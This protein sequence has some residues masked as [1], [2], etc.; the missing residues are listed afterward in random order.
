MDVPLAVC[1]PNALVL[2]E[3]IG[4]PGDRSSMMDIL[5]KPKIFQWHSI[6]T[7]LTLLILVIF[8][9]S[10]WSLSFFISRMLRD[11]MQRLLGDQQFSAVSFLADEVNQQ[12]SDRV[13][14]LEKV[15]ARISPALLA[16]TAALQ[17]FLEEH[18]ILQDPF[19]SG[20]VVLNI[21]GTTIAE[22][23][24][25]AERIGV[26]YMDRDFAVGALRDGKA[27]IGR[28]VV[29]KK[30][31]APLFVIAVPIRD[32]QGQV[33]GALAGVTNLGLP[34]FLDRI[35]EHQ[36]GKTGGYLLVAPQYRL[37]VTATDKSRI[38]E[39]YPDPGVNPVLDRFI[40]GYEGSAVYTSVT[41]VEILSS[42]RHMPVA[43]WDMV[44]NLPTAEAFA[45]I[46]DMQQRMLFAT[47]LLTLLAAALTWWILRHQLSP[48]FDTMQTLASMADDSQALQPLPITS[49]DEIGQLIGGF[50]R[51]LKTLEQREEALKASE[52]F[53][54]S[55]LNSVA[56]EIAVVDRDGIIQAVNER[57][58]RFA[59]E[60]GSE[61]GRPA[62]H[63]DV[64][65]DY[66]A[67]SKAGSESTESMS[68]TSLTSVTAREA[69]R[70]IESVLDGRLPSFSLEYP[71]HSPQKQRWF[72]MI[73]MPL[74][75]NGSQ[76]AVISHTDIT[77]LK[78]AEQYEQFRSRILE[79]LAVGEPLPVILEALALGVE[80]VNPR[81]LCSIMLL[82][83][84]GRHLGIGASPSLPDFYNVAM[85]G[86]EIGEAG[87]GSGT[88]A[89]TGQ[90]VIV[91]NIAM[92]P[93][94]EPYKALAASAGLGACWA[95]PILSATGQ[96]LGTF[97]IYYPEART[98]T[99]SD[100]YTI[101]QSA[102]LASI[103][104][105]RNLAAEKLR[106]SE[107]LYRL[108]TED[109]TDVAWKLDRDLVFTYIS[110]TDERLRGYKAEE[111]IGHHVFET[112]T[113]EGIAYL[114]ERI[115]QRRESER[116]GIQ[117]GTI[118]LEVQQRC[119][120]GR[121][122]WTEIL[123]TPE[124]DE[125]G[126]ITG[127]H[128]VSRDIGERK[129]AEEAL[130]EQKDFF[131]LIAE[132]IG[133]FIA[134]LDLEGRRLYNSPS[135][136]KFFGSPDDLFGSD[137]FAEIHPDDRERVKQVFRETVHTGVGRQI[138][139][140]F[141]M[142]DGSIR[143]MES[144]GNAIR[145]GE[146][147]VDRVVV[148]SHDVTERKQLEERLRLQSDLNQRYLDTTLALMVELDG[149]GKITMINHALERLLGYTE[150]ELLGRDWFAACIPEPESTDVVLPVFRQIM[151]GEIKPFIEFENN[152]LCRDGRQRMIAWYNSYLT[153]SAGQIVGSFS[154]G[155]DI[156]ERIQLAEQVRQL[157]FHDQLTQLPNRRLL[158]DRLSQAMAASKRS[159]CFGAVMF[160][161]LDNFKPLNDAHGHEVGDL[162]LIEVADRLRKCVRERDTVARFGGDEFVVMV[163]ELVVDKSGS[164]DQASV[165]AEKIR[166]ALAR[167]YLLKI[168]HDGAAELSV[169]HHCTASIG[170]TLFIDH[171]ASQNEIFKWADSAMYQAKEAGGNLIRFH[172]AKGS[173]AAKTAVE[174][175]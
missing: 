94:W 47:L 82:D 106:N 69:L 157:A 61:P 29:G 3:G 168:R 70:G 43:G 107:A 75:H 160:L 14:A 24:L 96:V 46:R 164:I 137:S 147:R 56:A 98:P 105:E 113:D 162:L 148:V 71:C 117:T 100:L 58:L 119:K 132:N 30:L 11:D 16:D 145:D 87:G 5:V 150:G 123:S 78:R 74:G 130:R 153:D 121:L 68:A 85:D 84:E 50:N 15:A 126:R 33:I 26:N 40:D 36:Y 8:V 171:Q 122:I 28:P 139:Y 57:W 67:F 159:A 125:N 97:A 173:V 165:I 12:L 72:T 18:L 135:Y 93:Y 86:I 60:N 52:A 2:M 45:P 38:M 42:S 134:V 35:S 25:V 115:R 83:S 120:D 163:S 129:R 112:L 49:Q 109:A 44:A 136:K 143:E 92:H 76:G 89:L 108:L 62:P 88:A 175:D 118:T 66:L 128:G 144:R 51:L 167:K 31:L 80:G 124:R 140:R 73:V 166:A 99:E 77:D 146:G 41:G 37:I 174:D 53:K 20:V 21:E 13:T 63:T 114:T 6:K 169:E 1:R 154:T 81:M 65:S 54:N 17:S 133:D 32:A 102:S 110:P 151:A 90:R 39:R 116:H 111:I 79:M 170:V 141:L 34:N 149:N 9:I 172:E 104:I 152:I 131:Y 158:D 22:A 101:K 23:A 10:I 156:T 59:Q 19:N 55:I 142:A 95:Q 7:R 91:E 161:D 103:A 64:G 48:I 138:S 127:Y 4:A 155:V 27:T